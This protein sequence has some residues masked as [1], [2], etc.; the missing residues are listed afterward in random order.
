MEQAG[1][2]LNLSFSLGL[3]L[4][5]DGNVLDVLPGTPAYQAGFI[6]GMKVVSVDGTRFTPTVVQD[7]IKAGQT[8]R[9]PMAFVVASGAFVKTLRV[10][11]HGG[12]RYPRLEQS[13]GTPDLLSAI[14]QP[15][16]AVSR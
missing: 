14:L 11:Y 12:E 8:T 13:T 3:R 1:R 2:Q 15:R 4:T 7:A 9:D 6:P 5:T 10:D 16:A